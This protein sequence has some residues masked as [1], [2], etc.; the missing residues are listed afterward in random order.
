MDRLHM[1]NFR[2]IDPEKI[3]DE[4]LNYPELLGDVIDLAVEKDRVRD[5]LKIKMDVAKTELDNI[6]ANLT[7]EIRSSKDPDKYGLDKLTDATVEAAVKQ[8]SSYKKKLEEYQDL[9]QKHNDAKHE[10]NQ[11]HGDVDSIKAKKDALEQIRYLA[12]MDWFAPSS[13]DKTLGSTKEKSY[14]QQCKEPAFKSKQAKEDSKRRKR[15]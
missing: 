11:A 12:G 10:S 15:K 8:Q 7:V 13:T 5:E 3:D 2:K 1:K 4:L 14:Y 9:I 6:K